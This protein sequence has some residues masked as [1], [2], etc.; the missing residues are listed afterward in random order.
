MQD[1]LYLQIIVDNRNSAVQSLNSLEDYQF[2]GLVLA[3][4]LV[5]D[6]SVEYMESSK[7]VQIQV[8]DLVANTVFQ[9]FRNGEI[10]FPQLTSSD[11]ASQFHPDTFT[12]L[13]ELIRQ[14]LVL[15]YQSPEHDKLS[16]LEVASSSEMSR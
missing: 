9:I 14:R 1:T 11:V 5:K 15:V 16:K 3:R 8:A 4:G 12:V 10:P 7:S 6:V 2:H 13:Y